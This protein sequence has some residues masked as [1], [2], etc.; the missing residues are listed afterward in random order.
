MTSAREVGESE[1]VA[2]VKKVDALAPWFHNF[3]IAAGVWTNASGR[4]PGIE[5][6]LQRWRL[7]E[8]LLPEING[9]SCLDVGC[10]SGFFSLKLKE[11]GAAYVLGIDFEQQPQAIEQAQ[12]AARA[13][14]LDVDFRSMSA[15]DLGTLQRKF[16]IVL[17]MGVFYHLRHP[18]VVLEAIRTLCS[19]TMIFQSITTRHSKTFSEIDANATRNVD[20]HS[21]SMLDHQFPEVRFVEGALNGDVT[22]WFVPNIQGATAILRSCGFRPGVIAFTNEQDIIVQCAPDS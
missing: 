22:C 18:L 16:D 17:F 20:L 1:R 13:L 10:S 14:G 4:F 21:P 9:K 7:I 3:E 2:L 19:G 6:P 11:L 8:P 15:Y 5:Y 12:F